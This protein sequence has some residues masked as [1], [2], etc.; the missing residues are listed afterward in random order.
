MDSRDSS[1]SNT[2]DTYSVGNI[3]DAITMVD[4]GSIAKMT[5]ISNTSITI[6]TISISTI[7]SISL[8]LT[9]CYMDNTGRVGNIPA[10]SSV[11]T[12]DSRDSS[13]GN[14]M[15]TYS[16]GNIGDA[17]T[18]VERGSITK[19]VDWGSIAKMSTIAIGTI[20]GISISSSK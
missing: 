12:M 18:M 13:R 7:E 5:T 16:V 11:S 1:R 6:S 9:L 17:L 8:S 4:R 2:M 20:E 15:D 3:G 10:S 14:T 19:S